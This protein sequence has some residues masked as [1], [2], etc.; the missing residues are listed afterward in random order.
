MKLLSGCINE[1]E[2]FGLPK[3]L[4]DGAECCRRL[5]WFLQALAYA[6]RSGN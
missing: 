5:S 1:L 2:A 4:S 3:L 6:V